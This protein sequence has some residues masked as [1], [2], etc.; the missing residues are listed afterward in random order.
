MSRLLEQCPFCT[1]CYEQGRKDAAALQRKYSL[2]A[3][4]LCG[5]SGAVVGL[6]AGWM[7]F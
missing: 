2:L 7:I 3:F 4:V 1:R 6:I 5:M